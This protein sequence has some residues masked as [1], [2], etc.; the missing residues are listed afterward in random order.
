M[1]SNFQYWVGTSFE[2]W[3]KKTMTFKLSQGKGIRYKKSECK[4]YSNIEPW[5]D[6][7]K[8]GENCEEGLKEGIFLS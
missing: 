3:C 4:S 1:I 6:V 8:L 5:W 7:S 2:Y